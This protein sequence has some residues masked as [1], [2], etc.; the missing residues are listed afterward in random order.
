MKGYLVSAALA[1]CLNYTFF[2]TT[3]MAQG[4]S[5]I[6]VAPPTL[7]AWSK[8]VFTD[9]NQRL[10]IREPMGPWRP[11]TGI[12]AVKFNCSETGAPAGVSLYKS[13]GNRELDQA[14]VRAVRQIVSLHPL[15]RGLGHEQQYIVRVL[16]AESGDSARRQIA[17]MQREA[18]ERNSWYAK[19]ETSTAALEL[20]PLG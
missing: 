20:V 5:A 17:A 4:D 6:I 9:L 18:T 2:P 3:T 7:T 13:S 8:K 14:T 1:A 11:Q 16:F 10:R 12:A 19:N 15:P